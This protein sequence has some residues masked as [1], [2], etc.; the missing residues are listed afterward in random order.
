DGLWRLDDRRPALHRCLAR[1]DSVGQEARVEVEADR[2][3][4]PRLL[5]PQDVAGPTDLEVGECDLEPGA[6]LRRV[7][8]RL[9]AL[10]GLVREPLPASIEEV[11]VGPPGRSAA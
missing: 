5:A 7:E 10:A 3:H 2:R 9:E 4:V 8:D 1:L 11:G 6:K